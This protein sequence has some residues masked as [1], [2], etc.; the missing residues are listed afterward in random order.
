M[1]WSDDR[2][3]QAERQFRE[4]ETRLARQAAVVQ[5]L[6]KPGHERAAEKARE[7]LAIMETGVALARLCLIVELAS[8]EDGP[9]GRARPDG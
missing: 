5:E 7:V 8:G 1:G 2:L 6:D 4:A 9:D 3:A